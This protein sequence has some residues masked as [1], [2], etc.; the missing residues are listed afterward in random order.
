LY[1]FD[2]EV[3]PPVVVLVYTEELSTSPEGSRVLPRYTG[4]RCEGCLEPIPRCWCWRCFLGHR[5]L[6]R[7]RCPR[8]H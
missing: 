4:G 7:C 8:R 2:V 5:L 6:E 3:Q 1:G